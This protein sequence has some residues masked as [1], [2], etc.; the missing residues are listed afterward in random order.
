M[1]L[2]AWQ[3]CIWHV[4]YPKRRH[5]TIRQMVCGMTVFVSHSA[6][7]CRAF[8]G[9]LFWMRLRHF[10]N[11]WTKIG[12]ISNVIHGVQNILQMCNVVSKWA[13]KSRYHPSKEQ[14][15]VVLNP[16]SQE[17]ETRC[18]NFNHGFSRPLWMNMHKRLQKLPNPRALYIQ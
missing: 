5:W 10:L 1:L 6:V 12:V 11:M 16:P 4:S 8:K 18:H 2:D 7:S 9:L 13:S 15:L 14:R 17:L 3:G